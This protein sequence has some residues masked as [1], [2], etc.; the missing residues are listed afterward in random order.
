MGNDTQEV[1]RRFQCDHIR[2]LEE[3]FAQ[4]FSENEN[5]HLFFV[6]EDQAYT[7][8]RNI[9]V[10]PAI[11]GIYADKNCLIKTGQFLNWPPVVLSTTWNA[12]QI[13]TR[14]LNI[15][16]C[17][18]I[19]YSDF[20]CRSFEDPKCDTKNK[21]TV[22]SLI[23]NIIEDAYIEAV[24][25]SIYDNLE[26]YLKFMR[27]SQLFI[28]RKPKE[29]AVRSLKEE[30]KANPDL[31]IEVEPKE[32][33]DV[34]RLQDYL[35]FMGDYL[36]YPWD[37]DNSLVP[38]D[39]KHY[40]DVS[41]QLF[42]EGCT[43]AS[44]AERYD[45]CSKIF[46]II[47]KLIPDD[48][49]ELDFERVKRLLAGSKT[50]M[51][52]NGAA[53]R[54][55]REGRSQEVSRRLFTD[56]NGRK[57]NDRTPIE[58]L[59]AVVKDSATNQNATSKITDDLGSYD[60]YTGANYDSEPLHDKIQ[61]NEIRPKINENLRRAYKNICT[62][63]NSTIRTYS[64]R[65]QQLLQ[66]RTIIRD[67]KYKFGTGIISSRLGDPQKRYWYRN[68]ESTDVPDMAVLLL[69]DGSGSMEGTRIESAIN[70]SVIIHEVLRNAGIK[71]AI[72]EQRAQY[73]EPEIDVNILVGFDARESEKLNILQMK[74][75]G[76]SRDGL[77]LY[78]AE[79][80]IHKMTSNEYKLLI[81]I[82]DGVPAH[83]YDEYYPPVST[84]DTANA[85]RRIMRRGT[86]IVGIA[87]DDVDSFDCY[88]AL[89]EIYPNLIACNDLYRLTSQL[90][91]II[92]RL[93]KA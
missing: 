6:N 13:I 35:A 20:P 63:Y 45:Y 93:L 21:R 22:M 55:K 5:V 36:L 62:K 54:E 41:R 10:D 61:I 7:D 67:E 76:N 50:H 75:D 8:G 85:V 12:L 65:I 32:R 9:I 64:N 29:T 31:V 39:I 84:K 27:V 26:F 40:V 2:T 70:S 49:T 34:D 90:L 92:A 44:P 66:S 89:R 72:V 80:Y 69:V 33:T 19:L 81:V 68:I 43:K 3:I 17:L 47:A 11:L 15:H 79:R 16:E 77:A 60:Y 1:L 37:W 14:A 30:L 23:S 25:S 71:H 57:R 74:A 59:M 73:R 87:L 38:A 58:Q 88:T 48:N 78:W 86:N 28:S 18:H 82:S 46:D 53:G 42:D 4:T 51:E 24:G 91:G 83:S 56:T 52:D